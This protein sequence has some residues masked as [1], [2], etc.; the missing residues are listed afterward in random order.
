MANRII[1]AS[2]LPPR[3]PFTST[4]LWATA[5]HYWQAPGWAWGAVGTVLAVLWV[6]WGILVCTAETV[7]VIGKLDR[8][9]RR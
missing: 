6:C 4:V 3:A 2:Q 5:L 9:D 1:T 7:D 8:L